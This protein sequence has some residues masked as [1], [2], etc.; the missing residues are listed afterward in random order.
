MCA[1]YALQYYD[2][3]IIGHAAIFGLREDLDLMEGLRYSNATLIFYCGFILGCYPVSC[4]QRSP[5]LSPGDLAI[6]NKRTLT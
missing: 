6:S 2:K 4:P 1:T 3:A 5:L